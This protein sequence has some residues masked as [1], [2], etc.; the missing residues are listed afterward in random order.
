MPNWVYNRV[1][2]SKKA[3]E[4]LIGPKGKVTF[5]K[6][7]PTPLELIA[8]NKFSNSNDYL[9]KALIEYVFNNDD[10]LLRN[11]FMSYSKFDTFDEFKDDA[12]SKYPIAQLMLCKDLLDKYECFSCYDWNCKFW[13]CK[14]DANNDFTPDGGYSEGVTEI[15][16]QTPW[17][18]PEGIIYELA[19]KF[20]DLE[21]TWH[22]DEESCAFSLDYIFNG[23]GT[24]TEENVFPEYYTPYIPEPDYLND[25]GINNMT[26]LSDVKEC[27]K[28]S[29]DEA[30]YV[31]DKETLPNNKC[32][33]TL[34]VYDWEV[35][36]GEKLYSV[37]YNNLEDDENA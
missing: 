27:I 12:L 19:D 31:I 8:L 6:L 32:N 35:N 36:G 20:P 4:M 17:T 26:T 37:T 14:W 16:F 13:G 18:P 1:H 2:G 23:D 9:I 34:T 3:I 28:D 21:L 33:I 10:S 22:A 11:E 25:V 24:V 29:L 5:Q 15:E 7:L 30:N